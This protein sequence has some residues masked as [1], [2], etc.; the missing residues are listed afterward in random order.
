[1][2]YTVVKF[3]ESTCNVLFRKYVRHTTL[4]Q[5]PDNRTDEVSLITKGRFDRAGCVPF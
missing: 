5:R 3:L 1:M 2:Q 4:L